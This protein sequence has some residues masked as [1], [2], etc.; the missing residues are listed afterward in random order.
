MLSWVSNHLL[1][2]FFRAFISS[3]LII[4]FLPVC[5]K[6]SFPNDNKWAFTAGYI[7]MS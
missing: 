5:S 1:L 3:P 6:R 4:Y 2:V 7:S